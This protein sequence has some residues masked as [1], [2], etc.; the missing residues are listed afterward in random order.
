M[1]VNEYISRVNQTIIKGW[2]IA[3]LTDE[4][5]VDEWPLREDELMSKEGRVLEIRVF[6]DTEECK[7]SRSDVGKEFAFR[8]IC[9]SED[10]RDSYDEVQFLDIDDKKGKDADGKV[11]ATGGGTY[12]LPLSSIKDAKIRIRYYL[13]KYD[14]TGQ[15]RVEDW[16]VVEFK[17]GV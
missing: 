2:I 14:A 12:K 3:A 5:I 13:G 6:N 1:T 8:R 4:Y 11:T 10:G 7:L 9:D 15:A 17:E 16:R